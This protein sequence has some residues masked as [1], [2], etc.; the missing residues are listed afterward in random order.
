MKIKAYLLAWIAFILWLGW[1][2]LLSS[3]KEVLQGLGS[4]VI[5]YPAPTITLYANPSSVISGSSTTV[6]WATKDTVTCVE[7]T[8]WRLSLV[9][10]IVTEKLTAPFNFKIT[11]RWKNGSIVSKTLNIPI[12]TPP[13]WQPPTI[14]LTANPATVTSGWTTLVTWSTTNAISCKEATYGNVALQWSIVTA[15]L[16]S[17]LTLILNCIGK[18]GLSTT[19]SLTIP[20]TSTTPTLTVNL[21]AN[22]AQVA[23][24]W[25]TTVTWSTTNAVS[26][27]EA[28][29]GN[30][31]LQWSI[32]TERLFSPLSLVLTCTG[33]DGTSVT[34]SILIP[35]ATTSAPPPRVSLSASPSSVV[36]GWTTTV[37]WSSS[38]TIR[39][40]EATYGNVDVQ[41]S[42]VTS[43]LYAPLTL[44]LT[45]VGIDGTSA[46]Q[47]LNIPI[48]TPFIP[49]VTM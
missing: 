46:T 9:W 38:N 43:R 34:K 7:S 10:S 40:S 19:K 4:A 35:V 32:V 31:A 1:W 11:C 24:G 27:R 49:E 37:T 13:P 33:R 30:V 36:S 39:C 48:T 3:D 17:P 28:T 41:W 23:S 12:I 47:S 45:C 18:D 44:I 5:V 16:Y 21:S 25:T 20:V 6:Y 26:C 8:Y 14:N 29:Y 22:P 2:L 42:V 15:Q